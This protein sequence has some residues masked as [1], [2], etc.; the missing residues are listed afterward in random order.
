MTRLTETCSAVLSAASVAGCLFTLGTSAAGL[1]RTS[2]PPP[3]FSAL[4]DAREPAL[5]PRRD[6]QPRQHPPVAAVAR[7]ETPQG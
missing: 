5:T 7:A 3:D 6:R 2:A 1:A 4:F